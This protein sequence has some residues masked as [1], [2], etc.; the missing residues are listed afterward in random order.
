MMFQHLYQQFKI[1]PAYSNKL[2]L[3]FFRF[4]DKDSYQKKDDLSV[5]KILD[6]YWFQQKINHI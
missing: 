1:R 5:P 2:A 4:F 6:T 3:S